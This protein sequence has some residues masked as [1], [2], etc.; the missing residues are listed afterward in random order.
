MP[1]SFERKL[2]VFV[3]IFISFW[4]SIFLYRSATKPL[5]ITQYVEIEKIN[6]LSEGMKV[7]MNDEELC[8]NN[9]YKGMSYMSITFS[10]CY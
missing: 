6:T 2:I 8:V 7:H 1:L 5:P 9:L 10:R 3:V 4:T